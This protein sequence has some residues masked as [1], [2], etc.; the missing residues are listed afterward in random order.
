MAQTVCSPNS[1]GEK[2]KDKPNPNA[3]P[4]DKRNPAHAHPS[5]PR[6]SK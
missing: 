3:P 1:T 2:P 6:P 5:L 4:A